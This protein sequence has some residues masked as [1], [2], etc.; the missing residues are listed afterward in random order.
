MRL[1]RW[2]LLFV[3]G[4]GVS[5]AQ[6]GFPSFNGIA[7][8]GFTGAPY[9]A[10]ET[11]VKVQTA[12]NGQKFT[13]TYVALLWRDSEGR[14]R[15][16]HLLKTASGQEYHFVMLTDPIAGTHTTWNV[17][18]WNDRPGS[19]NKSAALTTL[20]TR[21]KTGPVH[22]FPMRAGPCG[23]SCT[24]EMF[25]SQQVNGEYAQGMRMTSLIKLGTDES[26]QEI[27]GSLVTEMWVSPDLG[28][29]VHQINDD[30]R[31]GRSVTDLTDIVRGEP[32]PAL[33]SPPPGYQISDQRENA[34]G[35]S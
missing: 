26:G 32:D 3:L 27:K 14:L 21:M 1:V 33:F 5:A 7:G 12:A 17:G 20:S 11:T 29:I 15:E 24:R 25:D 18:P 23:N 35:G 16:E 31:T 2:S 13:N 30:P 10:K 19:N 4:A 8:I 6:A 28:I 22:T 34:G 9:S